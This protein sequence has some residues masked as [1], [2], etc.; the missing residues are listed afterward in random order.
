MKTKRIDIRVSSEDHDAILSRAVEGGLTISDY[1]RQLGTTGGRAVSASEI[2]SLVGEVRKIGNNINQLA[3]AANSEGMDSHI[4]DRSLV[5]INN[6][7]DFLRRVQAG[8]K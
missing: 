1:L 4:Y 6:F 8:N 3:R 5:E 7:V 2:Q